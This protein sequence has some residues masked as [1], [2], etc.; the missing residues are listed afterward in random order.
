MSGLWWFIIHY[1]IV[2][3]MFYHVL[4]TLPQLDCWNIPCYILVYIIG[5]GLLADCN[6]LHLKFQ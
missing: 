1:I 4:P 3:H 6:A 2:L 5:S